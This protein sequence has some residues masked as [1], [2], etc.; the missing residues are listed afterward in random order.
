MIL[1]VISWLDWTTLR[2]PVENAGSNFSFN[3]LFLCLY[4]PEGCG[5]RALVDAPSFPSSIL[6]FSHPLSICL[7]FYHLFCWLKNHEMTAMV[8]LEY[9]PTT[10]SLNSVPLF[11]AFLFEN[12]GCVSFSVCFPHQWYKLNIILNLHLWFCFCPLVKDQFCLSF[13]VHRL[14]N[15]SQSFTFD[16]SVLI[17]NAGRIC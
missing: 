7:M 16:V 1:S 10:H 13:G 2:W 9:S 15:E 5:A 3:V 8:S 12:N 6:N 11:L 14:P 4:S 17:G